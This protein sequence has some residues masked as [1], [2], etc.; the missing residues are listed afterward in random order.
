MKELIKDVRE[1]NEL[2]W[3]FDGLIIISCELHIVM[4]SIDAAT[5]ITNLPVQ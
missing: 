2:C 3:T 4:R 1:N 5:M